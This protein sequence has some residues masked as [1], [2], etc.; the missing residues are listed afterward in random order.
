MPHRFPSPTIEGTKRKRGEM[1]S[2]FFRRSRSGKGKE[3]GEKNGKGGPP[4]Q[5][6]E[7]RKK[8]NGRRHLSLLPPHRKGKEEDILLIILQ[9]RKKRKREGEGEIGDAL[10]FAFPNEWKRGKR[11]SQPSY[12]YSENK[13]K[14]KEKGGGGERRMTIPGPFLFYGGRC[15]KE[16]RR[17]QLQGTILFSL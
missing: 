2:A 8:K 3:R 4:N 1:P 13:R 5:T 9:V 17:S 7:K 16:K 10:C 14:V 15:E 6:E 12:S 11:E